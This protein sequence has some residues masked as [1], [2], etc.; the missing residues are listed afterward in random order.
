QGGSRKQAQRLID[1]TADKPWFGRT[2]GDGWRH[3]DSAAWRR[4]RVNAKLDPASTAARL[5]IPV[6]WFLAE[7]DRN[8]PYAKSRDAIETARRKYQADIDLVSV[9]DAAHSF[10]VKDANG[11]VHYTNHYWP[12]MAHWLRT[13]GIT[14]RVFLN[15]GLPTGKPPRKIRSAT[16]VP[17]RNPW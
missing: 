5:K 8:V 10:L 11:A 17:S 3:V 12:E 1:A 4:R 7:K 14:K 6:L 2:L 16:A 13:R 15:C 9:P